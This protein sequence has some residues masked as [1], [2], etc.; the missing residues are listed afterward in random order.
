VLGINGTENRVKVTRVVQIP[1]RDRGIGKFP[2]CHSVCNSPR[3]LEW[4]NMASRRYLLSI[5]AGLL[6][7]FPLLVLLGLL[8][9]AAGSA[10]PPLGWHTE[11][12]AAFLFAFGVA[13]WQPIHPWLYGVA[14]VP[15]IPLAFVV[16]SAASPKGNLFGL[17]L[18]FFLLSG[19]VVGL[20][21]ALCGWFA[22]RWRLPAWS[23][24]APIFA[25]FLLLVIVQANQRS[26]ADNETTAISGFLQQIGA[27]EGVYAAARA[28]HAYT[29][30]GPD[31]TSLSGI[32]WRTDYNLGGVDRNQAEHGIYWI[33]LH[34]QPAAHSSWFTATA[35]ALWLGG[36]RFT[37][38]SR[39]G[40]VKPETPQR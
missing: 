33:T 24:S 38:D 34:C 1:I 8:R 2:I 29:C 26:N 37:F 18:F 4:V 12:A 5:A 28:D 19:A 14:L 17:V 35:A 30:N 16:L 9:Y 3:M 15:S 6:T 25:A 32:A 40:V 13:L 7:P 10:S 21:A 27:A 11:L 22:R 23:P 39:S 31:L 20:T 36:P